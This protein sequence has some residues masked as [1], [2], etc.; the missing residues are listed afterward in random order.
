MKSLRKLSLGL[1]LVVL[2]VFTAACAKQGGEFVTYN[3]PQDWVNWGSVLQE[4]NKKTGI[5]APNDNKNSGQSLT[6]LISEK[7]NPLCDMVY[8]G[9][10]FGS[11]AKEADVLE[12][13]KHAYFNNI[14]P[15][16][17]E[18]SGLYSV[19]HYGSI[20]I[21]SNTEAL[22]DLPVPQSWEDLLDPKYKG[23]IG[24]LDPTSAAV[25]YSCVVAVNEAMSGSLDD[26]GPAIDYFKKLNKN[27]VIYPMQTSTAKLKKFLTSSVWSRMGP[28]RTKARN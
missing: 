15:S 6:A 14:D 12:P 9:I 11:K 17:K 22:G 19:V 18:E 7:D 13:Y 16:L 3:T 8:L 27:E 26:F 25:G 1:L 21:L 23:K 2:V 10:A 5:K 4:F 28:T 20:A 24:M